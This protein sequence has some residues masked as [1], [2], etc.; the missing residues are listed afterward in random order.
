VCWIPWK[1]ASGGLGPSSGGALA[2]A[3][4][5]VDSGTPLPGDTGMQ[6]G[7]QLIYLNL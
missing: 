2:T 3:P 7:R 1:A 5:P 6:G 4:C